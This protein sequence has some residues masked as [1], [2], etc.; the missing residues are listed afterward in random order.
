MKLV[1]QMVGYNEADRWLREVLEHL[2]HVADEI[3]FTDDCS[4]DNTLKMA[5]EYGCHTYKTPTQ[6]FTSNEGQL[7][8]MAWSNL[9]NHAED[10]DWILAIDCDEKLWATR[11]DLSLR[12]LME[13][14]KYD[15]LNVK[16]YHMW[17]DTQYRVDKAWR[18]GNSSRMFRYY[19]NGRFKDS[20]LACG[21]EPTYVQDLIRNRKYLSE[22]G[23]VMQHLGYVRDEDKH[24]KYE[25]YM[26]IDG[27][28]FHAKQHIESIIDPEPEL[29]NWSS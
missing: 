11:R 23:L 26:A 2:T 1:A 28:D 19:R 18:P 16:F 10:G 29:V 7:R 25:R 5:K 6:L 9:R 13:Q 21:S 20:R 15:V 4:T 17:N 22:S 24:A 14:S 8:S 3:V 27:G 12:D